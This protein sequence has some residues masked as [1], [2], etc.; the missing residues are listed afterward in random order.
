MAGYRNRMVH[1]YDEIT[2]QEMYSILRNKL[3]DIET[4]ASAVV[5]ILKNPGNFNLTV[6]E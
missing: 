2:E 6:E 5:N 3:S 1:F 4:F